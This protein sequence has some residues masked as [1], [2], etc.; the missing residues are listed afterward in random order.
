MLVLSQGAA[1]RRR[2]FIGLLGVAAAAWPIASRAQQSAVP[3]IVYLSGRS[4]E[5]TVRELE[6][7]HKGLS[8]GCFSD[9]TVTLPMLKMRPQSPVR[10]SCSVLH[11]NLC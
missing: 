1:M 5:D 9:A 11:P 8:E 4:P 7:F 2:E 3:L 6:A 10:T